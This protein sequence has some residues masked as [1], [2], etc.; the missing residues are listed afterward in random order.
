M[1]S[2]VSRKFQ[3]ELLPVHKHCH[4][5]I[6]GLT[7]KWWPSILQL[8]SPFHWF[9]ISLLSFLG[10]K[11]R[12]LKLIP[13]DDLTNHPYKPWITY[14]CKLITFARKT[15]KNS[16]KNLK[17]ATSMKHHH[18][19]CHFQCFILYCTDKMQKC[20]VNHTMVRIKGV[21]RKLSIRPTSNLEA[22]SLH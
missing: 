17:D 14:T 21:Y 10:S 22:S 15:N 7:R 11:H 3:K 16:S 4:Q 20:L 12:I 6:E 8:I 2:W 5:I 13:K 1:Q 19:I 9:T 18:I